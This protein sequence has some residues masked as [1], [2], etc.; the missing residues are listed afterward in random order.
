MKLRYLISQTYLKEVVY[1]HQTSEWGM[2]GLGHVSHIIDLA[3][4]IKAKNILDYGSGC[5]RTA[6]ELRKKNFEVLEYE[7]GIP[8]KRKNLKLIN[9]INFKTDLIICTDV[10]EHLERNKLSNVLKHLKSINCMYYYITIG[11]GPAHRILSNGD[12][13]HLIQEDDD[14]WHDI[15][16]K[17]FKIDTH[18]KWR[19]ILTK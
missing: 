6:N 10:L 13:A 1:Q 11:S 14:W 17:I 7:P 5:G 15:L 9:G 18:N 16:S 3:N 2:A 19:Y 8:S 12:N 4:R